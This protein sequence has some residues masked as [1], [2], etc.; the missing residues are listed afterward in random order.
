MSD[1]I[2]IGT[3]M[4]AAVGFLHFLQTLTARL[5]KPGTSAIRTLW[6]ALWNWALWTLFGAYVLFFWLIG[7]ILYSVFGRST[8]RTKTQ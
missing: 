6:Q 8:G 5:G 2:W 7:L 1:F 4:G 3:L